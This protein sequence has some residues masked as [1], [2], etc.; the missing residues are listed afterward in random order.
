MINNQ[1]YKKRNSL[2]DFNVPMLNN[3]NLSILQ[4]R[5]ALS[6]LV[7]KAKKLKEHQL[8]KENQNE[9]KKEENQYINY[10]PKSNYIRVI[11]PNSSRTTKIFEQNKIEI[12]D[13]IKTE[14]INNKENIQNEIETS[15]IKLREKELENNENNNDENNNDERLQYKIYEIPKTYSP[16]IIRNSYR[17]QR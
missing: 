16:E 12:I 13:K 14:N 3:M 11:R 1:K 7:N 9:S 5:T 15:P 10:S 6:N 4:D 2:F 17:K 8:Q